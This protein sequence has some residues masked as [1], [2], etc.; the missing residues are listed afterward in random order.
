MA[1]YHIPYGRGT[2]E[3][4]LPDSVAVTELR[5]TDRRGAKDPMA[6][7]EAA[8]DA[9]LGGFAW[10]WLRP[11]STVAIAVNDKTRP[12]PHG[13]L[14]P[15]LLSRLEA[16]GVSPSQIT[17]IIATGTH[18]VMSTEEF[19]QVLPEDIIRRYPV[20]CHDSDN[21]RRLVSLGITG[22][23]TPCTINRDFT[24]A[25]FR[26][27]VGNIEPHQFV[28]FSGGVKSAVI[29]LGGPETINAN[30]RLMQEEGAG[31]ARLEGNPV[32]ED[33]E[34]LGRLVGV[35]FA[36]NV[37]MNGRKEIVAAFAGAPDSV[38]NAGVDLVGEIFGVE[39][40]QAGDLVV[41]APGGHPKDINLYQAQKSLTA[42]RRVAEPGASIILVAACPEGTGSPH[43]EQWVSHRS[44]HR[45][46][47]EDFRREGFRIGP[48]KAF[49]IARDAID[50][51]ALLVSE[52]DGE[53]VRRLLL[54]P[55]GNLQ[56][57]IELLVARH[58]TPKHAIIL[59]YGNAT[60]PTLARRSS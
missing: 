36:L 56:A 60:V 5:P 46:V 52:M 17:L 34:E 2:L 26:I 14:L 30:H 28:G 33:I 40:P 53:R 59:P 23:G 18:P 19:S 21:T 1:G 47:I 37:V 12:V 51:S 38:V 20:I 11:G 22:R 42:A 43:Y 44:S 13:V 6:A 50:R 9:P 57:A 4:A 39:C 24:E 54:E 49:Q 45:E 3:F 32:R 16:A 31:L 7:V 35:H 55:A 58:G 29:G 25:D 41:V 48:H 27:V 8:L 10:S 15:P